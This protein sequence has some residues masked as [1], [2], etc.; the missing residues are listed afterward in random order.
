MQEKN[1]R[2]E[3]Q[4]KKLLQE[5]NAI[6]IAM[7]TVPLGTMGLAFNITKDIIFTFL[8]GGVFYLFLDS[9]RYEK[10]TE[11]INKAEEV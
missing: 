2:I 11:L 9:Y 7:F 6:L 1:S 5:Y 4:Y 3:F 10:S 8:S